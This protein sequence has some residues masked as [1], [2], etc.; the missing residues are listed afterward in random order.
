MRIAF[1]VYGGLDRVSGGFLYD[2]Q[3][4]AGLRD[5]G[6]TVEVVALPWWGYGRALCANLLPLP[7]GLDR[8]DVL[9]EDELI[10]PAVFL[11]HRWLRAR[12][13]IVSLVHN[14]ASRQ[15]ST[16]GRW[17]VR[18]C[19]RAYLASVDGVV[20]VSE[21]ALRDVR[22]ERGGEGLTAAVAPPGRD[23]I[24][25]SVDHQTV[26]ARA[27]APGPLRIACVGV[28]APHK[29][30]HRLLDVLVRLPDGG[31]IL[32]VAGS[33]KNEPGYVQ[34]LRGQMVRHGLEKRVQFH[35]QLAG[36]ALG[37][38]LARCQ[39]FALPS[40]RESYPIAVIEALGFGLPALIT[41]EGGTGE[42]LGGS[43][44]GE[45]LAP[46]DTASWSAAIDRLGRD[47]RLLALKGQ[48]AL[49]RYQ[50]HGTWRETA[51]GVQA[52]CE[53]VLAGRQ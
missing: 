30:L 41:S 13:P 20:A 18:A 52:L 16:R 12:V 3:V 47:R 8:C 36:A 4:V 51:R 34:R 7:A 29:G 15:P 40:D 23:H 44:C 43:A 24:D 14:L 37:A 53:R 48:A 10:H 50:A 25:P 46:D 38:M 2:R 32:E 35:G 26:A 17:L 5:L 21:S 49:A 33:L 28:V 9:I 27:H 1:L 42:V 22:R 39:L 45:L 31:A 19:E 11:R 6:H